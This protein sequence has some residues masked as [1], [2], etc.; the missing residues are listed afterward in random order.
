ML[1]DSLKSDDFSY[2]ARDVSRFKKGPTSCVAEI[3]M[4]KAFKILPTWVFLNSGFEK[5]FS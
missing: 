4:M 1:K 2:V 3:V 5:Q